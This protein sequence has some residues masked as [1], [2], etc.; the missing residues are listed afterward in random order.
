MSEINEKM[1]SEFLELL[2][3]VNSLEMQVQNLSNDHSEVLKKCT[4]MAQTTQDS[5]TKALSE[6]NH[7][8]MKTN[9]S[10]AD[11]VNS[12]LYRIDSTVIS[13]VTSYLNKHKPNDFEEKFNY[14]K[15][16]QNDMQQKI[17]K[18]FKTLSLITTAF[19]E[20]QVVQQQEAQ[21]DSRLATL[22][23]DTDFTVRTVN[24]LRAE[25]IRTLAD[26]VKWTPIQLLKTPNLGKKSL[27]E[28]QAGLKTLGLELRDE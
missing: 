18:T 16:Q 2:K 17:N 22:I 20:A 10:L 28:I 27:R 4:N 19:R 13:S 9:N 23:E 21:Q 25:N 15:E 1:I 5:V 3:K 12:A 24:C 7:L 26:L 11:Q 14:L 6:Q 8:V